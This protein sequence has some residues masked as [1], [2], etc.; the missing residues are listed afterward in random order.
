[1]EKKMLLAFYL[2]LLNNA[3]LAK[4]YPWKHIKY[5]QKIKGKKKER[6]I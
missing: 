2:L 6:N 1:V 3:A 4:I 5:K